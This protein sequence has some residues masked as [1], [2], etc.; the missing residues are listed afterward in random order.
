MRGTATAA[1]PAA[2]SA[3]CCSLRARDQPGVGLS[4]SSGCGSSGPGSTSALSCVRWGAR[5]TAAATIAAP[6]CHGCPCC[7]LQVRDHPGAGLSASSGCSSLGPA[8]TSAL[9][10]VRCGDSWRSLRSCPGLSPGGVILAKPTG[11]QAAALRSVSQSS[12]QLRSR[13]QASVHMA[14]CTWQCRVK[15][16]AG[17]ACAP[18]RV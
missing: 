10:C 16:L 11:P 13:R 18:A 17:A 3:P 8:S 1:G 7:G 15:W 12:L 2:S 9:S 5:A 6:S 14:H 4:A